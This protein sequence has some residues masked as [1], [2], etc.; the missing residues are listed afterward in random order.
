MVFGFWKSRHQEIHAVELAERLGKNEVLVID[1]REPGEF[2]MGHIPGAVNI[3]L[4]SFTPA[5]LPDP[6]GRQ[7]VLTCLGGKRSGMALDKCRAA[8]A[9]VD[10]HLKGG[11]A[12]W[13]ASRL[14]VER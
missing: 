9:A 5:R 3:P 11:M 12:A 7:L 13:Q 8:E 14:P 10:T 2:A 1:V 4:S 6:K